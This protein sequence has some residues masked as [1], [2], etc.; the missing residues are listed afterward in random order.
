MSVSFSKSSEPA[1]IVLDGATQDPAGFC[2]LTAEAEPIALTAERLLAAQAMRLLMS[3]DSDLREARAQWNQDWF[4][5]IMRIR[6]K[7]VSRLR[8]RWANLSSTPVVPL[9]SLQRRYH[10]NL[11]GYLYVDEKLRIASC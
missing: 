8:R 3:L 6:P 1:P 7:A 5:R 10:A 11:A 9:G 4:R 2:A